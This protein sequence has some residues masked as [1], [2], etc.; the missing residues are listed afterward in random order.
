MNSFKR[1]SIF[2]PRLVIGPIQVCGLL[3]A[4]LFGCLA[5]QSYLYFARFR[6]DHLALKATVSRSTTRFTLIDR[7]ILLGICS[8][9]RLMFDLIPPNANSNYP[10]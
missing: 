7:S 6:N 8:H 4:V 1:A 10:D 3:S 9:V 2:D 5:C